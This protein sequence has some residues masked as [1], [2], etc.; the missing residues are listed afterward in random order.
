M[1]LDARP[2]APALA[3]VKTE[4]DHHRGHRAHREKIREEEKS[5]SQDD[6]SLQ[7]SVSS[8]ISVVKVLAAP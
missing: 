1:A 2:R 3:A 7:E 5:K 6:F 8:V 4:A